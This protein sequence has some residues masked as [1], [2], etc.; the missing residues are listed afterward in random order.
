[1]RRTFPKENGKLYFKFHK[2]QRTTNESLVLLMFSRTIAY[3]WIFGVQFCL[4]FS[5]QGVSSKRIIHLKWSNNNIQ[6]FLLSKNSDLICLPFSASAYRPIPQ[7]PW[8]HPQKIITS[9]SKAS[10]S[11]TLTM[12]SWWVSWVVSWMVSAQVR[13]RACQDQYLALK[14]QWSVFKS[15]CLNMNS[16]L[17]TH[18]Y[19]FCWPHNIQ[20]EIPPKGAPEPAVNIELVLHLSLDKNEAPRFFVGSTSAKR[21]MM[22]CKSA[23]RV[24]QSITSMTELASWSRQPDHIA[25]P[26]GL[27]MI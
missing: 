5:F 1:M 25:I 4:I 11:A 14:K 2:F 20:I 17:F 18:K 3:L 21:L 9:G 27:K 24:F 19:R 22:P 13:S 26:Q 16:M 10:S 15:C 7:I 8:K 12:A 6:E 23:M